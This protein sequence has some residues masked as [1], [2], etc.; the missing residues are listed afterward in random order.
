MTATSALLSSRF[1]HFYSS[2]DLARGGSPSQA[3]G[4]HSPPRR[5]TPSVHLKPPCE[6]S[7]AVLPS[8]FAVGNCGGIGRWAVFPTS[9]TP[10]C[11]GHPERGHLCGV[12]LPAPS[13]EPRSSGTQGSKPPIRVGPWGAAGQQLEAPRQCRSPSVS[14]AAVAACGLAVWGLGSVPYPGHKVT[15]ELL[16]PRDKRRAQRPFTE[17]EASVHFTPWLWLLSRK[18]KLLHLEEKES[19]WFFAQTAPEYQGWYSYGL[20]H[21]PGT[22]MPFLERALGSL[23]DKLSTWSGVCRACENLL[24]TATLSKP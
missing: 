21:M 10:V 17:R 4:A 7:P 14:R 9:T 15:W 11:G 18:P 19:E 22:P 1:L 16:G 23:S 13:L 5:A 3:L 6:V 12:A 2:P 8:T 24:P 20:Q